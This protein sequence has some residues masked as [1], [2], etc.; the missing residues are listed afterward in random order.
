MP[1]FPNKKYQIIYA[2]P[3]W[4]YEFGE[5]LSRFVKNKY[6][7]M[8]FEEICSLPVGSIAADNS[9]LLMWATFPK[10]EWAIP[11]MKAWGFNYRTCAFVW[12]K[13]NK[14]TNVRQTSFLPVD[15][16]EAFTG[17]GY[18][19][20]SNAEICLLGKRGDALERKRHDIHQIVYEPIQEHS[21]KPAVVRKNIVKLFGDLSRIELFARQKTEGWDVWGNEV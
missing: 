5:T 15:N 1:D 16:L 6:P 14:K 20:R 2:D 7:L 4:D 10:L 8:T 17:M 13:A 9:I 21:R 19:T 18:Y 12:I 3:P 11:V